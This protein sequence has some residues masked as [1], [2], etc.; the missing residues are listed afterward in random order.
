MMVKVF[1]KGKDG[2]ISFTEDEL[3]K[4]LDEA[5]WEGYNANHHYVYTY[6]SIASPSW[7]SWYSTTTTTNNTNDSVT[8][9]VGT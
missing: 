5:Y 7:P 6:P 4:I 9:S 3:R 8:V 1:T 2:K